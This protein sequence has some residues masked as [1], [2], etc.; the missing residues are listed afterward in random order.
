MYS[1]MSD[2]LL[3]ARTQ[4]Q[5]DLLHAARAQGGLCAACGRQLESG[6]TVYFE[7]FGVGVKRLRLDAPVRPRSVNV[8]PVAVECASPELLG[9]TE[10]QC[11]EQCAACGRAMVYPASRVARRRATCSRRCAG[12]VWDATPAGRPCTPAAGRRGRER[13]GERLRRYWEARGR[14]RADLAQSLAGFGRNYERA[15]IRRY[16]EGLSTPRVGVFA[17]LARVLRVSMD[18][19]L[20][21]EDGAERVAKERGRNS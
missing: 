20:F 13:W 1:T 10:G 15:S 6:E 14:S 5:I 16:E 8:A 3:W 11:R 9:R 2:P 17:A 12:R 21:G 19:L 7:R 18:V 4:A